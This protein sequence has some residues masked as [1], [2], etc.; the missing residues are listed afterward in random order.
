M[1][2]LVNVMKALSDPGR[3]KVLKMLEARELCACEIIGL[4]GLAQP[5]VSRHLR[6]L[7]D[8]GLIT[9]RKVGSWVHYRLA[10]N[11]PTPYAK[12][13]LEALPAWLEDDPEV[14]A[15]RSAQAASRGACEPQA[16]RKA[17]AGQ[18]T[19]SAAADCC[20]PAAVNP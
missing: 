12:A 19:P 13:M 10:Q 8:A 15:L 7:A 6:V 1:K 18:R 20:A 17:S 5:T 9:G 14:L 16:A 2:E 3:V 11:P 4:L